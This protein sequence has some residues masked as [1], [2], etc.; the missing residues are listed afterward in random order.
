MLADVAVKCRRK[1]AIFEA[2]QRHHFGCSPNLIPGGNF[3]LL[4]IASWALAHPGSKNEKNN[5]FC[6]TNEEINGSPK[7]TRPNRESS[8]P[9]ITYIFDWGTLASPIYL[10]GEPLHHLYIWLGNPCITFIFDWGTLAAPIYL[11]WEPLHHLYI[12]LGN[13]CITFLKIWLG[14]PLHHLYLNGEPLPHLY[15]CD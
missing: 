14:N 6:N 12:R 13:P 10:I 9:V 2:M 3:T 7:P 15:I 5:V 11:I 8:Q 4:G 1:P